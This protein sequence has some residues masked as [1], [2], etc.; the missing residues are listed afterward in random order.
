[1]NMLVN[2][3]VDDLDKAIAFYSQAFGLTVGRRFGA[4]DAEAG[5]PASL[6]SR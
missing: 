6:T 1:M 5:V 4:F 2:L 3:D